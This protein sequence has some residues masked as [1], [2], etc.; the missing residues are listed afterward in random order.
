MTIGCQIGAVGFKIPSTI[1]GMIAWYDVSNLNT[2]YSVKDTTLAQNGNN[3][4]QVRDISYNGNDAIATGS[5]IAGVLRTTG[6][7][8]MPAI[9]C[10]LGNLVFENPTLFDTITGI[11]VFIVGTSSS[12]NTGHP[13]SVNS[14][15][16]IDSINNGIYESLG[17]S[18]L[19]NKIIHYLDYGDQYLYAIT[20]GD[21]TTTELYINNTNTPIHSASY[22]N[23]YRTATKTLFNHIGFVGEIQ[24]FNSKLESTDFI[25]K[26]ND[27]KAKWKIPERIAWYDYSDLSTVY[28]VINTTLAQNGNVVKQI[29]DKSSYNNNSS[30]NSLTT[31]NSYLNTTGI[32]SRPCVVTNRGVMSY[33][34][35]TMLYN[36]TGITVFIIAF[37]NN[38]NFNHPIQVD[39]A[40]NCLINSARRITEIIGFNELISFIETNVSTLQVFIYAVTGTENGTT[41]LYLNNPTIAIYSAPYGNGYRT[42]SHVVNYYRGSIGEIQIFNSKLES[43]D[44]VNKFNA[45]KT[46]WG[47]S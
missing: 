9:E 5:N 31:A 43:T 41:E 10:N 33:E 28:S 36:V 39:A 22:G 16:L 37:S 6:I 29:K 24:I 34:N 4:V 8:S 23:D 38:D 30:N 45:L 21:S 2:L 3:V 7:N 42:R 11:T 19:T 40:F 20:G 32:N 18:V 35:P 14:N 26:F 25:N 44:F 15:L 47:I 17:F 27:L 13:I 1:A 46:K 12:N